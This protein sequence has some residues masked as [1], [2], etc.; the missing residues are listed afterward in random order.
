MQTSQRRFLG[1]PNG[2]V[3]SYIYDSFVDPWQ[4]AETILIQ[5][6][7]CRTADHFYAWV[8]ALARHYNVIRR[9]LRG[10]GGS[11]YPKPGKDDSYDYSTTT[12]IDEIKDTL[13]QLGVDKVHFIG[14]S[15]SGM[16]AEIFAATY[17]ERTSSVVVCSS[18]THLP[19]TAL[20]F[21]AFGMQSWPEACRRLG[22][23]GWAEQLSSSKGTVEAGDP[24]YLKWWIDT[25]AVSDGEGLGGYAGFLSHLDSRPYLRRIQAPMLILCP[26]NSAVVTVESME[27]L[28]AE[29]S[30][31]RLEVIKTRGHE[32]YA[33]AADACLIKVLEFLGNL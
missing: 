26:S 11:S 8:P 25:V 3:T 28:G 22:S 15:T 24:N 16:L 18:P 31:A 23:R 5:H 27:E 9:D 21:F 30:T 12:I 10:H 20:D 19:Q 14:E 17:P 6:G 1:H 4:P 29:V 32:I 2:Q 7:F 33:E 13:D